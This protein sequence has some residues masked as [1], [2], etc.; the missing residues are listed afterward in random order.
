MARKKKQFNYEFA[1]CKQT[2]PSSVVVKCSKSGEPVRMYHKQLVK[3]IINKFSNNWELFKSSYIKKG[4]KVDEDVDNTEEFTTRPE[5]YRKYLIT[6]Y[7]GAK[8]DKTLT[9]SNLAAKL[10]FLDKCYFDRWGEGLD[11]AINKVN[12]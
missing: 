7:M 12:V 4:N 10:E 11:Q 3:L 5:G 2:L 8:R 1:D 9:P 6:A